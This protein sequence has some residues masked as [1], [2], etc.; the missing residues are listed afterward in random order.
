MNLEMILQRC[1]AG[2]NGL[3]ELTRT[4]V[5]PMQAMRLNPFFRAMAT[6]SPMTCVVD[7]CVVEC[8]PNKIHA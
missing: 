5:S 8:N 6:F 7:E 3:D 4:S 1:S 2:Q